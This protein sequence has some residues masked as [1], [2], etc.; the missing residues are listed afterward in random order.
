MPPRPDRV[1]AKTV[2][3]R[4][5]FIALMTA[6]VLLA[7]IGVLTVTRGTPVEYV[8]ARGDPAGPPEVGDSLFQRIVALNIGTDVEPGNAVQVLHNGN[9][10]YPILWRDI[11]A[12][13][14]TVT[15]QMYFAKP[16]AV[17]DTMSEVLRECARRKVRVLVLLD[18]FGAQSLADKWVK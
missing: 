15:V 11:R 2:V 6:L 13:Q 8:I 5:A 9:Q 12:C 14:Q 7:L 10:T 17:A 16:G 4:L 3:K 18:A 1:P